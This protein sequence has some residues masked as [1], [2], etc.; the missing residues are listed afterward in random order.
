[1]PRPASSTTA[2]RPNAGSAQEIDAIKNNPNGGPAAP[3]VIDVGFSFGPAAKDEG[4]LQAYKV[5][6]WDSIQDDAKDPDG[7]WYGDYYG[8]LAFE[9]NKDVIK[10]ESPK[11]WADLLKPEYEN[12]SPSPATR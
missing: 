3:D 4:L 11:D 6:T 5:A 2:S 10:G 1:M 8:V 7:F 9:I 12:R